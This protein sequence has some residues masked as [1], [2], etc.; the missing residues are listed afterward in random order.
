MISDSQVEEDTWTNYRRI[1]HSEVYPGVFVG[2]AECIDD[3]EIHEKI[4]YILNVTTED[5]VAKPD[6]I[7][8]ENFLR[9]PVEDKSTTDLTPYFDQA[10]QFIKSKDLLICL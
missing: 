10:V 8:N 2:S 4:D 7:L 1:H 3:Y 9:I 5:E 6:W